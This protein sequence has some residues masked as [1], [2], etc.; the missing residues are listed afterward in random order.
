MQRQRD[1]TVRAHRDLATGRALEKGRIAPAVQQQQRLFAPGHGLAKP[2]VE[3]LT[4]RNTPDVSNSGCRLHV[5]QLHRR[6]RPG[7][8]P[9]RQPN[10][11]EPSSD[12]GRALKTWRGAPE[13]QLGALEPAA[14]PGHVAGVVSGRLAILVGRFVLFV[15]H[16]EAERR[17]RRE[18]RRPGADCHQS[19]TPPQGPPGVGSLAIGQGAVED[20]DLVPK[21]SPDPG[22]GL[23]SQSDFGDQDDGSPAGLDRPPNRLEIDQRLSASGHPEHQGPVARSQRFDGADRRPLRSGQFRGRHR[24]DVIGEGVP[25][26][27][28]LDPPGKTGGDQPVNHA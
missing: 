22:H 2:G 12:I 25:I 20:R 6:Q 10:H 4:P 9:V 24:D 28:E 27:L 19:L 26:A 15:H 7:A 13:D 16:H 14:N 18:H 17:N 5:D 3:H 8:H 11:R 21:H 23:R 1:T